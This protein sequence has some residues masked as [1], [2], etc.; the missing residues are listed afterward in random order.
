MAASVS[1]TNNASSVVPEP[2][3]ASQA[4]LACLSLGLVVCYSLPR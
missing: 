1:Q 3:G 4:V 2:A